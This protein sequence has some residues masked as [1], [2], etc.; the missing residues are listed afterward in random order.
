MLLRV[1]L[2][3][4]RTLN[5]LVFMDPVDF[6]EKIRNNGNSPDDHRIYFIFVKLFSYK[7]F[8]LID[9]ERGCLNEIVPLKN[10]Q[11][12]LVSKHA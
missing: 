3:I 2:I 8:G 10:N 5:N 9:L 1:E 11:L 12:L 4:R 7:L 6:F